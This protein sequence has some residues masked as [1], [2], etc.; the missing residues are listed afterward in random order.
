MQFARKDGIGSIPRATG[1]IA[2]MAC[3]RLGEMGKDPAPVLARAGMTTQQASNPAI[4]LEVR[5]QIRLLEMAA[6]ELQDELLGFHLARSFD[7]RE[8]GLLYYVIAS[9][10]RLEDALRDAERYSR[11]L[12]EGIRLRFSLQDGAATVALEYVNVD[13]DADRHQIEFWLVALV[14]MCRQVTD[15][16]LA[17]SQLKLRHFRNGTPAEF[18]A[19]FGSDVEFGADGDAMS[20]PAQLAALPVA[21]RDDYLNEMLRQYAEEA[22]ARR[23]RPIL[24]SKVEATLPGLLPHGRATASEVARRLGMSSRTLSRKLGEEGTSFVEILDQLR[25]ALAKH[26]LDDDALPVS[27]IAWLL[28]Y[29]EVSSL[30]H[31]FKRRTGTSPRQFRSLEAQPT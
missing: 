24:R 4:R 13:R 17:P 14:R 8:I 28:G 10:E 9:S 6:G 3:A 22:L 30:T 5:T 11:I 25:A 16:R 27:E 15:T 29:R 31:A 1:G 26:Y 7:L 12:N 2:R 20:F 21:G 19:F 18:R 23:D